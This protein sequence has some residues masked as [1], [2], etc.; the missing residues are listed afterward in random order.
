MPKSKG[1]RT[2]ASTPLQNERCRNPI[3]KSHPTNH[4]RPAPLCC[5][6]LIFSIN[7]Y[8]TR[9]AAFPEILRVEDK[10]LPPEEE[11]EPVE[12][13]NKRQE[14]AVTQH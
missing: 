3:V 9:S 4:R 10:M 8:S 2:S 14:F 7:S 11:C 5:C 13:G 6:I 12:H 1:H